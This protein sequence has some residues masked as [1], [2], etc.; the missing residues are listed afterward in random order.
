MSCKEVSFFAS[1]MSTVAERLFEMILPNSRRK[2]QL[3]FTAI[4]WVTHH[5]AGRNHISVT[6]CCALKFIGAN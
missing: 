4:P 3:F 5:V 6:K 1:V 2:Y